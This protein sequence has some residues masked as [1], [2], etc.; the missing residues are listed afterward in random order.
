M[1]RRFSAKPEKRV[2]NGVNALWSASACNPSNQISSQFL[3]L[4]ARYTAL[5]QSQQKLPKP[6]RKSARVAAHSPLLHPLIDGA[7]LTRG[8]L[9]NDGEPALSV[10]LSETYSSHRRRSMGRAFL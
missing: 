5:Q 9:L 6:P 8:R 3:Y 2:L 1:Q 4:S 10:N 7:N